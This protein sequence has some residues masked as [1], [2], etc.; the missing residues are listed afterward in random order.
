MHISKTI[1][2]ENSKRTI[3]WN[4]GNTYNIM[5]ILYK[6][7]WSMTKDELCPSDVIQFPRHQA[8]TTVA[9]ILLGEIVACSLTRA[10]IRGRFDGEIITLEVESS[11][12]IDNVKAKIQEKED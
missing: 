6:L 3:V 1:S 12:T 2:L 4:R 10:Q 7:Y 8:H 11:N 9:P 5:S